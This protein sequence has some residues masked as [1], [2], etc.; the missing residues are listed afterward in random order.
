MNPVRKWSIRRR[1]SLVGAVPVLLAVLLITSYHM[2]HR[3]Q[4]LRRESHGVVLILL[5]HLSASAEYPIISGNYSLLDAV[6]GAALR[7]PSIMSVRILD[8]DGDVLYEQ[9]S[10]RYA[11]VSPDELT[12]FLHEIV[13]EVPDLGNFSEFDDVPLLKR[14]LGQV[15]IEVTDRFTRELETSILRQSLLTGLVVV[16][17]SLVAALGISTTIIPPLERLARFISMLAGDKPVE[18]MLVDDGAE[19][20]ALQANANCLADSLQAA[21]ESQRAYTAQLM[22][23]QRKTQLASQAK[24]EFLSMMSHELR[25]PL[26]GAVGMLQLLSLENGQ[27]EFDEYKTIAEDSLIHL[28]QLLEDVLVLVSSDTGDLPGL[29]VEQSLEPILEGLLK[30]MGQKAQGKRLSFVVEYDSLLSNGKIRIDPSML[31]QIVRHVVGNAI[32]FTDR[33]YVLVRFTLKTC[34]GKQ[35][36]V[37]QVLDSGIG[38]PEDKRELVFEAFSQVSTSFSRQYD[39]IGLGL[40]ITHHILQSL[41]G[42]ICISDNPSGGTEV[43]LDIP[44][45]GEP[46]PERS[47]EQ[48]LALPLR[49]MI[50]EDNPVN[51]RVIEHMLLKVCPNGKRQSVVSGEACLQL[52]EHSEKPFDLILMDCQMPGLDGFE[53]TL[54]MRR[55]DTHTP[56]V[57][58]T[59][60]ASDL[61]F[62]RCMDAGMNDFLAKPVTIEAVRSILLKWAAPHYVA[63]PVSLQE[64]PLVD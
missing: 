30:E 61:V 38:I 59:A 28:T 9:R 63:L 35:S 46:V 5:E 52:L 16:V 34:L 53:T 12:P 11:E 22:D 25:T 33:G 3:W 7:Q 18:H 37:I 44:L 56:V 17:L 6:V 32:K 41:G 54:Q 58:F 2:Y 13:Q 51:V 8:D 40:T 1:I 47:D 23:E 36:L 48:L 10:S 14:P 31:R 19:I 29:S 49:V 20:G 64:P 15:R 57:A 45:P 62:R 24:S 55:K 4:E 27:S 42:Q 21:R 50:V 26:N 43:V 60:N 39:G